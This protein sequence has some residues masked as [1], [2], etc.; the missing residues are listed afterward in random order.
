MFIDVPF[1]AGTIRPVPDRQDIPC[2]P[3]KRIPARVRGIGQPH[4]V[5]VIHPAD[6]LLLSK[7]RGRKCFFIFG[8]S[9]GPDRFFNGKYEK[10]PVR[11]PVF[12]KIIIILTPARP[13]PGF[14]RFPFIST[15]MGARPRFYGRGVKNIFNAGTCCKCPAGSTMMPHNLPCAGEQLYPVRAANTIGNE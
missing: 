7:G 12:K 15:L 8:R 1:P 4:C 9:E 13:L 5:Q 11:C 2:M 6:E 10:I 14:R 3:K